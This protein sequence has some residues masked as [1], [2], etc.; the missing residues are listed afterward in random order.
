MRRRTIVIESEGRFFFSPEERI[1]YYLYDTL[2]LKVSCLSCDTRINLCKSISCNERRRAVTIFL[3]P[4]RKEEEEEEDTSPP[5]TLTFSLFNIPFLSFYFLTSL[6]FICLAF[7]SSWQS[8]DRDSMT[9]VTLETQH[10]YLTG[11]QK[12]LKQSGVEWRKK[13][14]CLPHSLSFYTS[15]WWW[16][17]YEWEAGDC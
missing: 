12:L 15:L 5:S 2:N 11:R 9:D 8:F 10:T 1:D 6:L 17:A 13:W 4:D 16:C 14:D 7:P 3:M